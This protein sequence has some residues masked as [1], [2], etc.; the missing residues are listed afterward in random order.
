VLIPVIAVH[1]HEIAKCGD[2]GT[3]NVENLD[4]P[5]SKSQADFFTEA[6]GFVQLTASDVHDREAASRHPAR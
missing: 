3:I 1:L 6:R 4:S 2:R 5:L